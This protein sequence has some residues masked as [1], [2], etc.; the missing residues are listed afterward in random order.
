ML[1]LVTNSFPFLSFDMLDRATETTLLTG[2]VDLWQGGKPEIAALVF[3]TIALAP[4]AQIALL[5]WVLMPLR[6]GRRPW[7]LPLAFRWLVRA[8]SWSML[9]V[10][11][12][13]ILVAIIKLMGL[14]RVVPGI[15]L[16]AFVLLIF[17]LS[18]ALA[19]YDPDEVWEQV[20]K[21][22]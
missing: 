8:Q 22:S 15:A 7:Q 19:A 12:I 14:A 18:G 21:R 20:E 17:V 4:L 9:E 2:I 1:F 6:F 3:L 11:M 10:F 16:W 13:G 5:L